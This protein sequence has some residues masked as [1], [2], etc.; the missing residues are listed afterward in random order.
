[1]SKS[2]LLMFSSRSFPVYGFSSVVSHLTYKSLIHSELKQF[3]P[4]LFFEI[5]KIGIKN[6]CSKYKLIILGLLCHTCLTLSIP[7]SW[8]ATLHWI[9]V[10]MVLCL[11]DPNKEDS[12]IL[13]MKLKWSKQTSFHVSVYVH[14]GCVWICKMHSPNIKGRE[15]QQKDNEWIHLNNFLLTF[16][17]S[18]KFGSK[19]FSDKEWTDE[20]GKLKKM[21]FSAHA[22]KFNN[23]ENMWLRSRCISKYVFE[24]FL[25]IV[26]EI[27]NISGFPGG[28]NGGEFACQCR[29][30]ERCWFDRWV[31][32]IPWWR[33]WK[34]TPV[35]LAG[36]SHGQRS[37][38]GYIPW[39]RKELDT[40]EWLTLSLSL[41]IF[42][43]W[44]EGSSVMSDSLWP[45]GLYSYGILQTRILGSPSLL[46][47]IFPIQGSNPG[48]SW[49][50]DS[51]PA[52]RPGKPRNTGVG[53]LS[54]L[55]GIF[56]SQEVNRGLLHYRQILFF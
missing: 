16:K 54:L 40:T 32:K 28:S 11:L 8:W 19:L 51:L 53:S 45:H 27:L 13:V 5:I 25:T 48:L 44:E 9:S 41:D 26:N 30:P 15:R 31:G 49:Q 17:F 4:V 10:Q 34:P 29:R 52:E 55:Q 56:L 22:A 38:S 2:V 39:G 46:Q 42:M 33:A 7:Q 23:K 37:L 18:P 3:G 50:V 1:M 24:D 6:D 12:V 21:G 14:L 20:T 47:G 35:F 43:H 36:E